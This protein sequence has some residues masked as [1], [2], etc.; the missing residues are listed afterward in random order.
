MKNIKLMTYI[1][2]IFI[3]SVSLSGCKQEVNTNVSTKDIISSMQ[4]IENFKN[5]VLE[6][7]TTQEV[8]ERYGITK[9]DLEEGFVYYPSGEERADKIIVLKVKDEAS[10]ENMERAISAELIGL[11]D[12]WKNDE[13]EAKKVEQHVF[14]TKDLY[15]LLYVGENS[16][17][18]ENIFDNMLKLD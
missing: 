2:L 18:I 10:I 12:S 17:K 16:D 5:G 7:L 1:V 15:I 11:T 8:A 9:E 6:D 13:Y 4:S 3:V 14:K